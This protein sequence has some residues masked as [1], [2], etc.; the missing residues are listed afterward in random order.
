MDPKHKAFHGGD[1]VVVAAAAQNGSLPTAG[2]G[3]DR[4]V[5]RDCQFFERA[6]KAT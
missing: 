5:E 4:G 3:I 6:V 2:I 1:I